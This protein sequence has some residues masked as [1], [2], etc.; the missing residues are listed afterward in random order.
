M[1]T[2]RN[3]LGGLGNSMF[4]ALAFGGDSGTSTKAVEEYQRGGVHA[5][6]IS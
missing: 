4:G 6:I 1:L 3:S 2:G 5:F